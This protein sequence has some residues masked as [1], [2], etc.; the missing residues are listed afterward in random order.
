MLRAIV[1]ALLA[2][3][4][5]AWSSTAQPIVR[6]TETN[7]CPG[8]TLRLTRVA[9]LSAAADPDSG[10]PGHPVSIV[11]DSRGRIFTAFG[12]TPFVTAPRVFGPDGKLIRILGDTTAEGSE[13]AYVNG[14]LPLAA[15]SVLL[16]ELYHDYIVDSN[17]EIVSDQKPAN[18]L[19]LAS[20]GF[21][22]GSRRLAWKGWDLGRNLVTVGVL[23]SRGNVLNTVT[24]PYTLG[25]VST[26]PFMRFGPAGF[27][28]FWWTMS[29]DYHVELWG[30][31]GRRRL[32]IQRTAPWWLKD[33]NPPLPTNQQI[34]VTAAGTGMRPRSAINDLRGDGNNHLWTLSR[35][36]RRGANPDSIASESFFS[37]PHERYD[38]AIEVF[39]AT[40]GKLLVSYLVEGYFSQLL[41]DGYLSR[42]IIDEDGNEAVEIWKADLVGVR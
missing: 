2:N 3:A 25:Q 21:L 26:L 9:T 4:V 16:L 38:S 11:R 18:A 12:F 37:H 42:L 6:S 40:T 31:D 29:N 34:V 15:D 32:T 17:L 20:E 30:T 33:S 39:D 27:D 35:I 14:I 19:T 7:G 24:I 41:G 13:F 5:I 36:L 22:P 1:T 23:D 10:L 28:A 8:C